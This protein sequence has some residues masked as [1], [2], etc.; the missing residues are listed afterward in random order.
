[1]C[2]YSL[3]LSQDHPVHTVAQHDGG[4][5]Q[6]DAVEQGGSGVRRQPLPGSPLHKV[7]QLQRVV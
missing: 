5:L 7:H 3:T 1:M 6:V 4:P 2:V